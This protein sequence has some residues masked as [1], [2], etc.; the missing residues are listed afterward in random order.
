MSDEIL[1]EILE[2][3]GAKKERGETADV[4]V[5]VQ[6]HPELA[7]ELRELWAA[8]T[9]AKEVGRIA[10][11]DSSSI[12]LPVSDV[13]S[14][15]DAETSRI[16]ERIG[17]YEILDELGRGGM[18]VVYRARQSELGRSVALKAIR[19]GAGKATR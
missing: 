17:D 16:P 11:V 2:E 13:P 12:T 4:E 19:A 1:W 3:L 14:T 7:S 10:S 5:Y 8:A 18:G 6:R 9:L 15:S